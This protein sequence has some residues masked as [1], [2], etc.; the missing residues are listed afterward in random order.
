MRSVKQADVPHVWINAIC[1]SGALF[2]YNALS[3][4][5]RHLGAGGLRR[6]FLVPLPHEPGV[7]NRA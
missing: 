1:L 2:T 7:K 3:V 4:I 5:R 6:L